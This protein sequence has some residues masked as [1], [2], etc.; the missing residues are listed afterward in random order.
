MVIVSLSMKIQHFFSPCAVQDLGCSQEERLCHSWDT[1]VPFVTC[2]P[3][4]GV[5]EIQPLMP[6]RK[7]SLRAQSAGRGEESTTRDNAARNETKEDTDIE[8]NINSYH[9][10]FFQ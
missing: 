8:W 10:L 7:K 4:E 1:L 9:W 3:A 2:S 6:V 5:A